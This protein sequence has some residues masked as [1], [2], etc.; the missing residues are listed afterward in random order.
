MTEEPII[1]VIDD[2]QLD[3]AIMKL[4]VL[5]SKASDIIG[6]GGRGGKKLN[7]V[8]PGINRE[9]RLILGQVPGMRDA[10]RYYFALKRLE[11]AKAHMDLGLGAIMPAYLA[12]WATAIILIREILRLQRKTEQQKKELEMMIRKS[13]GWTH[14]EYERGRAEWEEYNRSMPG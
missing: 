1:I 3:A 11:R 2:S 13:R 4:D 14:E 12:I 7:T 10:M 5:G 8:L 6:G 9:L